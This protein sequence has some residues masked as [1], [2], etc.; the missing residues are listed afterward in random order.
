MSQEELN[1]E[2]ADIEAALATVGP[3]PSRLQ[4]DRVMY[5]A[6]R[7]S[8][9]PA[10]QRTHTGWA[11]PAAFGA[12]TAVA[13]T[14]LAM[15]VAQPQTH[16]ADQ[17]EGAAESQPLAADVVTP[18]EDLDGSMDEGSKRAPL[19]DP[20]LRELG[21]VVA[22]GPDPWAS[23][24]PPP[25]NRRHTVPLKPYPE[26]LE[27]LLKHPQIGVPP[28]DSSTQESDRQPGVES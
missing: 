23:A 19:D 11:W 5:L 9:G 6:G 2:L 8:V 3:G 17:S 24:D 13:A 7:A 4:R 20:Y 27:S 15:V 1:D 18:S 10:A 22:L 25:A 16:V 14:L 21:R 28:S 12:M 26:L